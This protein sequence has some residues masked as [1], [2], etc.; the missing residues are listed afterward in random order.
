MKEL[1]RK[2]YMLYEDSK[3]NGDCSGFGKKNEGMNR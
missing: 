3:N 2:G 1:I